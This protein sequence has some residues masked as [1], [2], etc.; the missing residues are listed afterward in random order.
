VFRT[1]L[2]LGALLAAATPRP[3]EAADAVRYA[4]RYASETRRLEVE[5]RP[6]DLPLPQTVTMPRAIPMG[7]GAQPYDGFV[8]GLAAFAA[9]GATLEVTRGE[10]PRWIV[11]G[12]GR[13][14]RVA[15][16]VDL[17]R[18]EAEVR[19]A[20][21]ASKGRPGYAGLLG[22]S[23]L[24]FVEGQEDRPAHLQVEAPEGWP[25]FLTLAPS[26]P[27]GRG[28]AEAAAADYYALADSQVLMGPDLDVRRVAGSPELYVA[29]YAEA[30]LDR[31]LVGGI[32]REAMDAL[33][34]W[35]GSAPF[36]HYSLVVE[37]LQPVSP[38]HEYGFSMEHLD[39]G[40][41]FLDGRGALTAASDQRQRRRTLYNYAHHV[42]HAWI[43]K[44]C[45]GEG[46]F[47]FSWAE[48][49]LIDSIWFSEGF[50]Q[51]AAAVALADRMGDAGPGYLEE[52]VRGR[53]QSTLEETPDFIR[54]MDTVALSR[55]ASTQYSE[56]FRTGA[57]SFSRGGLMAR[58]MDRRIRVRSGGARSL[59]D[60]LR[61]LVAWSVR[62]RRAFRVDEIPALLSEGSG[63][64]L[65]EDFDRWMAAPGPR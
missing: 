24:A 37:V 57:N 46:Y 47:P 2:A 1:V 18:L 54:E 35:F 13:L 28:T 49:P 14:A 44:R 17:G 25:V 5:I 58:D 7:Y 39:S 43:P 50:A 60:A 53:F 15:Y 27:P 3:G 65:R 6:G 63:V 19:Q 34:A 31:E 10:G 20:S 41:F 55:L 61:F 23:V 11:Q 38:E 26:A 59:R 30:E 12:A 16:R 32:G 21:D 62:E 40:T 29:S 52:L 56:D 4:V 33:V 9:D 8:E 48:A 42:A 45:Y 51:Y 64:D 36:S 22:Y